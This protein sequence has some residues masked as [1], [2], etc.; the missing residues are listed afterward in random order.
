MREAYPSLN[1]TEY[2]VCLLSIVQISVEEMANIIGLGI[3]SVGKARTNI[4]KKLNIDNKK[5]S[6]SEYIL[7]EYYSKRQ[8][9][10]KQNL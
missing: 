6:I 7:N 4:R 2:K 5:T 9:V 8:N 3:D 1:E 10:S